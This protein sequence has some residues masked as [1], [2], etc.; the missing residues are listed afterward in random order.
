M[1]NSE[2]IAKKHY[3]QITDDHFEKA[4]H[5]P[6]QQPHVTARNGSQGEITEPQKPPVL[7]GFATNCDSLHNNQRV[8]AGPLRG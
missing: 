5:N 4:L 6:M 7:Q 8:N 3:L 2:S 1:G